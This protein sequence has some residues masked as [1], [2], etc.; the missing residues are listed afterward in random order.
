MRE[1]YSACDRFLLKELLKELDPCIRKA[2]MKGRNVLINFYLTIFENEIHMPHTLESI[3]DFKEKFF[4]KQDELESLLID[5]S[6]EVARV[7]NL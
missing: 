1:N 7:L 5:K 6:L 4:V 2:I 3:Y